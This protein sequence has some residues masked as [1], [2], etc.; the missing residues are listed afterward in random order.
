MV[1]P[2]D[3]HCVNNFSHLSWASGGG[4]RD[5]KLLYIFENMR[6]HI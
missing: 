4:N 1:I 6:N 2:D 5:R 3:T